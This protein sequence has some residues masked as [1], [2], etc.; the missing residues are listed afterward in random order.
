MI[1]CST[2][3]SRYPA[4]GHS[5]NPSG[6]ANDKVS[7]S[8]TSHSSP[9]DLPAI[10][11][12]D[13]QGF[14]RCFDPSRTT[15]PFEVLTVDRTLRFRISL[16]SR[17]VPLS[18]LV[19]MA[20]QLSQAIVDSTSRRIEESDGRIACRKGCD[21]CCSYLIPISPAEA[22]HIRD[23]IFRLPQSEQIT[24]FRSCQHTT[25]QLVDNEIPAA[26]FSTIQDHEKRLELLSDWYRDLVLPC[27]FLINHACCIY[28]FRPLS[29][30]EY[31]VTSHPSKCRPESKE[32]STQIPIPLRIAE[33]LAETCRILEDGES[34][35]LLPLLPSFLQNNSQRSWALYPAELVV[36]TFLEV[37]TNYTQR[38]CM[39]G[40]GEPGA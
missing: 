14:T 38:N 2:T 36:S 21:A 31:C 5:V 33:V 27:P 4:G 34:S 37:L 12:D 11:L 8:A 20:C 7:L 25:R 19:P 26:L 29:C 16:V 39:I 1:S 9:S 30:R 13:H 24:L 23:K 18:E 15:I 17:P 10:M 28:D 32:P 22:Y 40:C 6:R 3:R 35:I